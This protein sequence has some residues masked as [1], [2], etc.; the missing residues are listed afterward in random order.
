MT[1]SS[2]KALVHAGFEYDHVLGI[3]G[4]PVTYSNALQHA[5]AAVAHRNERDFV[6]DISRMVRSR[7]FV[8]IKSGLSLYGQPHMERTSQANLALRP[9][10][11]PM[12]FHNAFA[13]R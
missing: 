13:D 1:L 12:Q 10:G 7:C 5:T 6:R 8:R 3:Q 2:M 4:A 9:D 11:S